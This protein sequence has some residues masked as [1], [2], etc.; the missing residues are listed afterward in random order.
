MNASPSPLRRAFLAGF[1]LVTPALALMACTTITTEEVIASPDAAAA[2][3]RTPKTDAAPQPD[4]TP[5]A[6]PTSTTTAPPS[7]ADAGKKPSNPADASIL[8]PIDPGD[9]VC[10]RGGDVTELDVQQAFNGP[11]KAPSAVQNVCTQTDLN[12]VKTLFQSSTSVTFT[13]LKSALAPSCASCVFT[14]DSASGWGMLVEFTDGVYQNYASCYAH[15]TNAS[16]AKNLAYFDICLNAVCDEADCG[17]SQAVRSCNT[18]ASTGGCS[19]FSQSVN[20]ACGQTG[21]DTID[22]KCGNIFQ[23]MAVTCGGGVNSPLNTAP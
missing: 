4:P 17:S 13:A 6:A 11:W 19:T 12:K 14:P 18:K 15:A 5:T 22:S 8:P 2:P 21:L 1:V 7:V 9:P 10:P 20:T 16:C 3:G 23:L